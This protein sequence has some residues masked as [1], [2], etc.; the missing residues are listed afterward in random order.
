MMIYKKGVNFPYPVLT[1]LSNSYK[2][3]LF[4]LDVKLSENKD[5]YDIELDYT[6]NSNFINELLKTEQAKL[7][8]IVQ[9][10]D[11]K[12]F[13]IKL[14]EKNKIINKNRLSLSKKTQIQL[15]VKSC[16]RISFENNNEICGLYEELKSEIVVP[17]NSILA[18]SNVV[19]FNESSKK[20]LELFEK[21]VDPNIKSEIKI[22]LTAETI[23][24]TYKKEEMM[25]NDVIADNS[26]NNLYVYMGLQRALNEFILNNRINGDED[27]VIISEIAEPDLELDL[28]L[29]RLMKNKMVCELNKDNIDEVIY[30]ISDGIV[31]GFTS[32]IRRYID[33]RS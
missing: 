4:D 25:F 31:E 20:G 11:N 19:T 12:F 26:L 18:F 30:L 7:F 32:S 9:S 24:I 1:N 8:L 29:Y 2:S 23:V 3:G 13:E 17:T 27:E 28:K 5:I 6:I 14:E 15:M 22:D 10:I 16:N 33:D 21:R